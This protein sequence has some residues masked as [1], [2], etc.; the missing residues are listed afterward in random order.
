MK[1][2]FYDLIHDIIDIPRGRDSD[3]SFF[4]SSRK[5]IF[6]NNRNPIPQQVCNA[7]CRH[8]SGNASFLHHGICITRACAKLHNEI[9]VY[10][11]VYD[12]CSC[13]DFHQYPASKIPLLYR[14]IYDL[15]NIFGTNDMKIQ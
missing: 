12:K 14:E 8:A 3:R 10:H 2:P 9:N 4:Y 15:H 13:L 7:Q 5:Y 11:I 6:P 1:F